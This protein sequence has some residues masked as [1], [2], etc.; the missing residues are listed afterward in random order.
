MWHLCGLSIECSC[1]DSVQSSEKCIFVF[2]REFLD[3]FWS[4][5]C[6]HRSSLVGQ[7][8]TMSI[9]DVEWGASKNLSDPFPS[10]STHTHSHTHARA[11]THTPPPSLDA[12]HAYSKLKIVDTR[13]NSAGACYV[14]STKGVLVLHAVKPGKVFHRF[15]SVVTVLENA[16]DLLLLGF[17]RIVCCLF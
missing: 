9:Q 16:W 2:C 14:S 15:R 17:V 4:R 13:V 11:R 7:R 3:D 5:A 10:H 12:S 6:T 8:N 1:C